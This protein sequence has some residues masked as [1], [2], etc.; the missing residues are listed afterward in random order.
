V[1]EKGLFM[2]LHHCPIAQ[3]TL[4]LQPFEYGVIG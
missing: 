1:N 4:S 3:K 2:Y